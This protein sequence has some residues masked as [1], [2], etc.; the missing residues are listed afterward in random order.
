MRRS[1]F[2]VLAL[3][4]V[5]GASVLQVEASDLEKTF[6]D[7][8]PPVSLF[9][10]EGRA[11]EAEVVV[12]PFGVVHVFWAY[13]APGQEESGAAQA[14]YYARQQEGI[15]SE[16]VD[17]L[18]SPG[19]RVARMP[20][21]IV[22]SMGYLHIVWSGGNA[23][24]YSSAFAPEAGFAGSW[25]TPEPLISGV[26]ALEPAIAV[27]HDDTL[28]VVWTQASAGLVFTASDDSGST[29][30]SPQVIFG[31]Y[32]DN[33]LARW[34]RVAVDSRG[35]IHVALTHT[36][37]DPG[38]AAGRSDPN[39]LYYLYS[40]D[41]GV[42]WSEPYLVTPEPDFGEI[43]VATAGGNMVHLVWNGRAGRHGR[44]H[45]WSEDGGK[46]WSEIVEVIAP[47][48]RNPIG[49]G[50]LTGFPALV[51]DETGAL[52]MISATG[53]GDY[54]LQWANG[55]WSLP[56]LVSPGL[57]GSGLTGRANSLEQPSVALGTGNRLHVVFHD[58]F[59]RIWYTTTTIDAPYQAPVSAPPSVSS[60]TP[61]TEMTVSTP[62][63]EETGEP[64]LPLPAEAV[65]E[66]AGS[67]LVPI[68][69]GALPA[70]ALVGVIVLVS[71]RRRR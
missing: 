45:R 70:V 50:G 28:Y 43:N 12:D 23:L 57:T 8:L 63:K 32:R 16:P 24:Y 37:N 34:G 51:T 11:S 35:R 41:N 61:N 66:S 44:Y 40:D 67:A 26:S 42:T 55:V 1:I 38:S 46:T 19:D 31:A 4:M 13:G 59:E 18:V 30:T 22:D 52:H 36:L 6:S 10:T 29:W 33:E 7:W 49:T 64:G 39:F 27:G 47:A 62:E 9:E 5:L 71:T 60:E 68:L 56:V 2:F 25:S 53:G 14:I 21:V 3:S 54:Y 65:P 48:P 15:W 69:V 58:G 20:S 17:V